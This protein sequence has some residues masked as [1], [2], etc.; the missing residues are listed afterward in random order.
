ML[1]ISELSIKILSVAEFENSNLLLDDIVDGNIQHGTSYLQMLSSN[2]N[3]DFMGYYAIAV[4]HD[5]V[6]AWT[7][8]FIDKHFSFHGVLFGFFEKLYNVFPIRFSTAFVSSPIAE[9]NTFHI[10]SEYA[11]FENI[12][13]DRIINDIL[14]FSKE[15]KLGLIILKDHIK[16]YNSDFIENKFKHFHFMPGTIVNFECNCGCDH[17]REDKCENGCSCFDTYLAG[18][19]K[20]WRS[21]IRNKMNHRDSGLI[22]EIVP[23]SSL[24][25]SQNARCYELY[26]QTIEKQRLKHEY[27][28]ETYLGACADT[29]CETCKMLIAKNKNDNIIGFAQLLEDTESVIN[30]RMGMDYTCAK[31]YQ[32]YYHLLYENIKYCLRRKKKRLYTSQ[33]CY[34]PKLEVGAQLLPLHSYIRFFNPL[35][36][37]IFGKIFVDNCQCYSELL[38][39]DNPTEVL[40]KYNLSTY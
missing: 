8:F 37:K 36:Q 14:K 38:A 7:F 35:L 34:R 39:T 24:S 5:K 16:P 4:N 13:V 27:I 11:S 33:T 17:C 19:K 12:I 25:E 18:L 1:E 23:A 15:E 10:N 29:L 30:V 9:Y 26:R 22:I 6:I 20:K 31:E 28:S 2:L 21:N 3:N 40:A 32:L